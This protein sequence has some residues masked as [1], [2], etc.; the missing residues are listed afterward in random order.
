V[1]KQAR[2]RSHEELWKAAGVII[3]Q[4]QKLTHRHHTLRE[5]LEDWSIRPVSGLLMGLGVTIA[6]FKAV[7]FIGEGLI[8]YAGLGCVE[9]AQATERLIR[10]RLEIEG[11][12]TTRGEKVKNEKKE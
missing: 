1:A 9:R 12:K 6:T 8:T 7:R 5:L 2:P 10:Q 4:V 3:S 11:I